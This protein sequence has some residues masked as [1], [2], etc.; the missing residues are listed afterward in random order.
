MTIYKHEMRQGRKILAIW[1]SVIGFFMLICVFL[2]PQM[3]SEMDVVGEM[4]SDMGGFTAAFGMDRLDFST[5]IGYYS[6]E[7]GN[8]LGIGGSLFAALLGISALAK[9]EREHTAEF[10]L[11]HPVS[12]GRV[13][14]EKLL[15]L[16]TQIIILNIVV[17]VVSAI[18]LSAI[19]EEVEPKPFYLLHTAYLLLQIQ[20]AAICF[21]I[22]AYIRKGG[23]GIGL[24]LAMALYFLN[25][26]SNIS[27]NAEFLKY[28]TPFAYADAANIVP[29]LSLDKTLLAAGLGYVLIGIIEAYRQYCNKDISI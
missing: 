22:S 9:E 27:E 17:F 12:R 24:G 28:I 14:S 3:K 1:T 21:G 15:A 29:E 8:I 16:F 2:Y 19:G 6:I 13:V 26:I 18:S 23:V 7:C 10:L 20:I 5:A 11:S 4:F 25:I